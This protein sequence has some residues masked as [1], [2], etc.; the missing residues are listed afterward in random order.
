MKHYEISHRLPAGTERLLIK[1]NV[2]TGGYVGPVCVVEKPFDK[3]ARQEARRD[4]GERPPAIVRA[5][6]DTRRFD[7]F[8]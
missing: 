7:D 5:K 4:S 3:I 6:G 1:V 2:V 8:S